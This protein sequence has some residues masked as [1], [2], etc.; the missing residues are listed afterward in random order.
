[1]QNKVKITVMMGFIGSLL[2]FPALGIFQQQEVALVE[3]MPEGEGK[4]LVRSLCSSCHS[5]ET[6]LIQRKSEEEWEET[7]EKMIAWGAQM[8]PAEM[9][10]ISGYLAAHY[11]REAGTSASS[12]VPGQEL[13]ARKCSQC[14]GDGMWRESRQDRRGWEAT[15]YRMV[16]QGALWTEEEISQMADYL[17]Q[18]RGPQND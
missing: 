17:A 8:F 4:G 7:V 10:S 15:L 11:V 18:T 3:S 1:M 13:F 2:M 5:L 14:H 9:E 12:A 16:G 6:V